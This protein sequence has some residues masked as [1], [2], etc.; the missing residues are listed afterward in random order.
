M[1]ESLLGIISFIFGVFLFL[2]GIDRKTL[3]ELKNED[4]NGKFNIY[5]YLIS[6][7]ALI[8]VGVYLFFK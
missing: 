8:I 1:T 7:L 3:W 6:A 4:W 2:I 5:Q